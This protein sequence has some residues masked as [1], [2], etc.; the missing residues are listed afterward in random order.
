[1]TL[2]H[3]RAPAILKDAIHWLEETGEPNIRRRVQELGPDQTCLTALH[4][5]FVEC[6]KHS[7]AAM[8][9]YSLENYLANIK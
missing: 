5:V 8:N 7:K 3:Q 1:M 6:K 2:F 9:N 4:L